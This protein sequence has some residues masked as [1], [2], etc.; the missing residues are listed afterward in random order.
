MLLCIK[1]DVYF[2]IKRIVRDFPKQITLDAGK[3]LTFWGFAQY[4]IEINTSL[5]ISN[6]F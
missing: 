3:P 2:V 1:Y 4:E 6:L 5:R